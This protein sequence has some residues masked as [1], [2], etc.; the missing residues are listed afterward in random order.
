VLFIDLDGFKSINDTLG[1]AAGDVLLSD[2]AMRLRECMREATPSAAWVAMN[3]SSSSKPA[4]KTASSSMSPGVA[5]IGNV[6]P[7]RPCASWPGAEGVD[8]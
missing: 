6:Q 2:L 5:R 8:A 1:H 3:S 7:L 4:S